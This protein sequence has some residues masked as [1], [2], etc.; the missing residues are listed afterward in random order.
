LPMLI[1]LEEVVF[2]LRDLAYRRSIVGV[3]KQARE[4]RQQFLGFGAL[5]TCR[6]RCNHC[7]RQDG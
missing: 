1:L 4:H 6:L 5:A 3:V 2:L 7:L